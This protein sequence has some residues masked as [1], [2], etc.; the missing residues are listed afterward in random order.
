[1]KPYKKGNE[2]VLEMIRQARFDESTAD[3]CLSGVDLNE[4]ICVEYSVSAGKFDVSTTYLVEAVQ[5]NNLPAV[6]YLLAHGADPN[7]NNPALDEACPLWEL[8]YL[9]EEDQSVEDRFEIE[10]LF[11]KH[12]ADPNI[13]CD[14]ESLYEY[15]GFKVFEDDPVSEAD[16]ENLLRFYMLL[17]IYGG[18]AGRPG[19]KKP[20]IDVDRIDDYRIE[21]FKNSKGRFAGGYI[22]DRDG[23]VLAAL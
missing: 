18:G 17:V 10:K 15:I 5:A 9:W 16:W 21:L 22:V 6:R 1:M 3:A 11:F 8:Q 7:Y 19:Y 13:V 20:A 2:T 23:T 12:G 4:P 14:R